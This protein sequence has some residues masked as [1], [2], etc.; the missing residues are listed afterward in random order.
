[1]VGALVRTFIKPAFAG[2]ARYPRLAW[3]YD[4]A[5]LLGCLL[6]RERGVTHTEVAL[7]HCGARMAVP[8][9]A[10]PDRFVVYLHGGAFLI[11]GR[12]LHRR[13]VERFATRL[14]SRV[15]AVEYRKMP[16]YGVPVSV[17]DAVE[18]YRYA[19][20]SGVR[21]E[22][23]AVMGDSAG[24]YLSLMVAIEIRDQGLAAPA[25]V[26]AMSPLTD[27]DGTAKLAAPSARTCALFPR[28]MVRVFLDYAASVS[29]GTSLVSPAHC[30][31]SGLAPIL[32]QA[33]SSEMVYPDAVLMAER[34]AAY[35]TPCELQIWPGQ[36]HVFQAA[37]GFAPE[38][39]A[40]EAEIC[41]FVE[42]ALESARGRAAA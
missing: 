14:Q 30:D 23:I 35:Q 11:G 41:S 1:L 32:I 3:P 17:A 20:D 25:A 7:A 24:G 12:H 18:A 40:A 33:S 39:T 22:H 36:V 16:R 10:R 27:W 19:L 38:A 8:R 13:M 2:W 15:L 42:R 6:T 5:D 37:A 31:L 4:L 9:T 29:A 26:V 28:S 34:L 21:P